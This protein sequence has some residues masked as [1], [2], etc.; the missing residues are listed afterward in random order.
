MESADPVL[1]A[2]AGH[3]GMKLPLSLM[4]QV[5]GSLCCAH[6]ATNDKHNAV[7]KCRVF[8]MVK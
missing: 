4:G 6:L 3:L 8:F 1:G 7:T 5:W 2:A